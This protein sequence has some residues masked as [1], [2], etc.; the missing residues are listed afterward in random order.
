[1]GGLFFLFPCFLSGRVWL[2]LGQGREAA[3]LDTTDQR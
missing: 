3:Q 2:G 1:M